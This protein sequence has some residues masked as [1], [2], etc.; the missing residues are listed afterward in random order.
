MAE[1]PAAL[2]WDKVTSIDL[3]SLLKYE[4]DQVD[5]LIG[6]I[7]LVIVNTSY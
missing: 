7:V 6:M 3:A 1:M 5:E 2:E 4:K